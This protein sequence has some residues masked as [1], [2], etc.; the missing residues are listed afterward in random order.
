M[1][2]LPILVLLACLTAKAKI[3]DKCGTYYADGYYTEIKSV[4]HNRETKRVILLERGTDSEIRFYI[5]NKNLKKLIPDTHLGVNFKLKLKFTSQCWY[6][7]EGSIVEVIKPLDPFTPP[8]PFLFPRPKP[9][10]KTEV[11]CRRN[12]IE[13]K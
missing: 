13:K 5:N 8:R 6:H 7:C 10:E 2:Y 12:S 11:K 4:P 3:I 9:I 1:K